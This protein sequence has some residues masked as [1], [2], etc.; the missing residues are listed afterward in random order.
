MSVPAAVLG[1]PTTTCLRVG[2]MPAF[3]AKG[4]VCWAQLV[5]LRQ[6]TVGSVWDTQP[7][8]AWLVRFLMLG[9]GRGERRRLEGASSINLVAANF[10]AQQRS[11]RH[12]RS[13]RMVVLAAPRYQDTW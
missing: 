9:S 8:N 11:P 2:A 3:V 13:Q 10:Q 12:W 7:G 1:V 6:G 4:L 5:R